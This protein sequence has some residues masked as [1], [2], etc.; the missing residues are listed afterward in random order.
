MTT[1]R[2][3]GLGKTATSDADDLFGLV[4]LLNSPGRDQVRQL[5]VKLC[6][7]TYGEIDRKIGAAVDEIF[8]RITVSP[9]L[10][11]H[12]DGKLTISFLPRSGDTIFQ[13]EVWKVAVLASRGLFYRI[14]QCP[15]ARCS[16]WFLSKRECE[17]RVF[18][19]PCSANCRTAIHRQKPEVMKER[20]AYMR[21]RYHED[22]QE[23]LAIKKR[24]LKTTKGAKP[25]P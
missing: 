18:R 9:C 8:Q 23:S 6:E 5:T 7:L 21:R 3:S 25:R 15:R 24:G 11:K 17:P 2:R 14:H 12:Q 16:R 20:A 4:Q 1:R 19:K 10:H 13:T 22:V